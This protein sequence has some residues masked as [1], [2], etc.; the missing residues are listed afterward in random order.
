[1]DLDPVLSV[2]TKLEQ[3]I[4]DR[5]NDLNDRYNDLNNKITILNEKVDSILSIAND[6]HTTSPTIHDA[7]P[8]TPKKTKRFP[9]ES[10]LQTW[11]SY[12]KD[13]NTTIIPKA[14]TKLSGWV[15]DTRKAYK[16]YINNEP[17]TMTKEREELLIAANFPFNY[18]TTTDRPSEK[19]AQ[20]TPTKHAPKNTLKEKEVGKNP[21][22]TTTPSPR[23]STRKK[24]ITTTKADSKTLVPK[25]LVEK[26][27]IT[28]PTKSIAGIANNKIVNGKKSNPTATKSTAGILM[29][30]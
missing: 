15:R 1:M 9:F 29:I 23:S 7:A 17:S 21:N 27:S 30:R 28:P 18:P 25:K 11:Q 5:Y 2:L 10:M 16:Q 26:K 22:P 12:C 24:D 4:N 8:D 13:N 14:E 20:S 19:K 3:S 6:L